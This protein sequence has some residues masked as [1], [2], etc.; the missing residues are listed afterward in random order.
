MKPTAAIFYFFTIASTSMWLVSQFSRNHVTAAKYFPP[1]PAVLGCF[2]CTSCA[3][4]YVRQL[5]H[6]R[7]FFSAS[8]LNA[9]TW[10][11]SRNAPHINIDS[12]AEPVVDES[13]DV[14]TTLFAVS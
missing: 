5:H 14:L 10:Q 8:L 7:P 3:Q 1:S 2:D 13:S 12:R 9:P 11:T 4:H 6:T